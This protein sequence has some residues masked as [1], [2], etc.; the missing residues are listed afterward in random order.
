MPVR[1]RLL[2]IVAATDYHHHALVLVVGEAT[3][4]DGGA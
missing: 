1:P 4:L 2:A 3:E